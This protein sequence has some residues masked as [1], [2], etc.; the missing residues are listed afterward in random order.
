M[1]LVLLP[2][3]D[4]TGDLFKPLTDVLP[5][6]IRVQVIDYDLK[7]KQ[8]YNDL[9]KYV[10]SSLPKED[11]ILLAES[12]SGPIAYQIALR[13]PKQLKSLI[14]VATFLENPR[15]LL[16]K[17][18]PNSR[19]FSLPIPTLIIKLFFLGFSAKTEIIDLFKTTIKKVSPNVIVYRLKEIAQLKTLDKS[20]EL[21]TTYIQASNDKLVPNKSLRSWQ[22]ICKNI[23]IFQVNGNH[24]ILQASP[25]RCAEIITEEV[26]LISSRQE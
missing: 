3:L 7:N 9:V 13:K 5:S 6:S 4:G 15:P 20:F 17:F 22:K 21:R 19:I 26:R 25:S 14:L 16:L 12:F 24:F 10:I 11:F 2:G 23:N 1:K 8:S 18:I